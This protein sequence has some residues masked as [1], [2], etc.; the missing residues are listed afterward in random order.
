MRSDAYRGS[1][2]IGI[3]DDPIDTA[4]RDRR[5]LVDRFE[6]WKRLQ[7]LDKVFILIIL[8]VGDQGRISLELIVSRAIEQPSMHALR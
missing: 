6:Y 4:D 8:K 5:F 7:I 2:S 3:R 1:L